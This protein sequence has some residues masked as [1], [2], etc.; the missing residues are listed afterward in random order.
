[1]KLGIIFVLIFYLGLTT[2]FLFNGGCEL[3]FVLQSFG[4]AL[5]YST[6]PWSKI[7]FDKGIVSNRNVGAIGLVI[8][9][10]LIFSLGFIAEKKYV[11]AD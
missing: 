5:Q 2:L 6:W 11:S 10:V 3:A 4:C 9:I 8:N 7:L 1:M